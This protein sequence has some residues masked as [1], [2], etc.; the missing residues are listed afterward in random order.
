MK[1]FENPLRHVVTEID[2]ISDPPAGG[3]VKLVLF[4]IALPLVIGYFGLNVWISQ[5]ARWIGRG[6]SM[7]VFGTEA[8]ALGFAYPSGALFCHFR[9][10]WGLLPHG[11]VYAIGTTL[12]LIGFLSGLGYGMYL[13][14]A[15]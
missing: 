1:L 9:W 3:M 13:V 11:R 14:L 8:R 4:G 15:Y 7:D 10:F 5:E 6:A 12:S 2:I